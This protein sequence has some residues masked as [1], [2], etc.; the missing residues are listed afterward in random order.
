MS[1]AGLILLHGLIN[2]DHFNLR[3]SQV[4]DEGAAEIG[5]VLMNCVVY[6]PED[7]KQS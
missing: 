4:I 1:D 5:L 7:E 2:F 3:R 6:G